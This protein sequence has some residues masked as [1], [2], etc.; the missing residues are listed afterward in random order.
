[1]RFV[2]RTS[3]APSDLNFLFADKFA[4]N[5]VTST[6]FLL[7]RS[8]RLDFSRLAVMRIELDHVFVCTAPGAPEAEEFVRFGLR[9]GVPNQHLGQGTSN[10][11]FAFANAMFEL[12]W[13][14]DAEEAQ[15][16][17]SRRTQLWERWSGREDKA[18]PFGIC[19]RPVD[20]HNTEPP[21]P[22]WQYRP[23]YLPDPLVMHLGEAG[24]EEPM[25]V[26]LGFMRRFDREQR[27]V[28]HPIGLCEITKLTL[29]TPLPLRSTA[30]QSIVENGILSSQNGPKSL[31]EIEFDD[32]VRKE[33]VDFRPHLPV[34]F[35]F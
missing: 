33:I 25:W 32:S 15:N 14:N 26:Y 21:F 28:E 22:A 31:L 20:S 18:S 8:N 7:I 1:M 16:E 3:G 24:V 19:V 12:V 11:R 29:T 30:S 5:H 10:R 27:F 2:L 34:V 4:Q 23:S 6:G 9:E 35:Q 17:C 13:V